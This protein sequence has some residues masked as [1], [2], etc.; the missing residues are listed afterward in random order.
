MNR[1]I[2]H[3]ICLLHHQT[4][5]FVANSLLTIGQFCFISIILDIVYVWKRFR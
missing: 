5:V 1:K 3:L 2:F 4:Q